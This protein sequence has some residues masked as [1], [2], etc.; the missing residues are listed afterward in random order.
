MSIAEKLTTLDGLIDD[1]LENQS[2]ITP[3]GTKTITAN[4]TYDV[5]EYASAEVN[6]PESSSP[7]SGSVTIDDDSQASI[8]V[9]T[10][11][12]TVHGFILYMEAPSGVGSTHGWVYTDVAKGVMYF[13]YGSYMSTNGWAAGGTYI[14]ASGGSVTCKRYGTSYAIRSGTYNWIA[15]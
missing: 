14:T 8:V 10:G 12:D 2:G 3:T 9:D 5:T 7:K 15:W 11:L 13:S 6:V 4:G 1:L